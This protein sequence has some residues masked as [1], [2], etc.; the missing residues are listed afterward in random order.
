MPRSLP[1]I[2]SFNDFDT[3]DIPEPKPIVETLIE[4][5]SKLM[6]VGSSKSHKTWTLMGLAYCISQPLPTWMGMKV[7]Q[8]RVL[9]INFELQPWF[10]RERLRAI[11]KAYGKMT[12]NNDHLDIWNL[13]GCSNDSSVE[14]TA[15]IKNHLGSKHPY[16][17]TIIDPFYKFSGGAKVENAANDMASVMSSMD[18]ITVDLNLAVVFAHHSPKGDVSARDVVDRGSGSGVFGREP[19]AIMTICKSGNGSDDD[20]VGEF[21]M[22]NH[23]PK[24]PMSLHWEYPLMQHEVGIEPCLKGKAGR[25]KAD[26]EGKMLALLNGKAV[27]SEEWE[28]MAK[29][30]LDINHERY[31]Q[32][33]RTLVQR[34]DVVMLEN[35]TFIRAQRG[36]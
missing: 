18:E 20:F 27:T 36:A 16:H 35:D 9:Y 22:R 12:V 11:N 17:L 10:F 19:D 28:Q 23:A 3:A 5:G 7:H 21:A 32:V 25:P 2:V 26:T 8:A 14:L 13:R 34:G 15:R 1:P 30:K 6:L 33:R 4:Q 24:A 29:K 31:R